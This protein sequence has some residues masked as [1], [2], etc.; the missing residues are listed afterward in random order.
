MQVAYRQDIRS[1]TKIEQDKLYQLGKGLAFSK[2]ES[3]KPHNQ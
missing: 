2:G 3:V 1:K